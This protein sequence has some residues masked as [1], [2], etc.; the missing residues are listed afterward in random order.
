MTMEF[1]TDIAGWNL[2]ETEWNALLSR[3]AADY[4]F[5]RFEF[6]RAWWEHL[7]GG[8]WPSGELRIAVWREAGVLRGIAPLFRN[9]RGN[10]AG[11]YFIGS[12]EISDY[13]DVITT[14]EDHPA[15]CAALLDA[16]ESTPD[17]EF[18]TL[19]LFN[20]RAA[21]PTAA[22]LSA[23]AARRGWTVDRQSLQICPVLALPKT[24]EEYLARLDKKDRH[25]IRRKLR[26]GE[27]A[28]EPMELILT[29]AESIEDFFRLMENDPAK[30]AFLTPVM[31]DQFRAIARATERT[32]LLQLAFLRTEGRNVAA[33]FN[34]DYG[35]RI[36]VYNSGMDPQY[37]ASSPGW[38]LLAQ[39]VRRA[40]D[41]GRVAFDFMRG[42]ETYKFQWGG[43]GEQIHRITIHRHYSDSLDRDDFHRGPSI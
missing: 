21:S 2:L 28:E 35:N 6:Q 13:L 30:A 34:F 43:V 3:G 17:P 33:Y 36:W 22:V 42:S 18:Q 7:G 26:R 40:I 19:D 9:A 5:L 41:Q 1:I 4:P 38:I 14:A 15:F 8:E 25:E 27:N 20:L 31:R 11:W 39:L 37:A 10:T 24:W 23:E 16:L 32:G 29:G 12:T